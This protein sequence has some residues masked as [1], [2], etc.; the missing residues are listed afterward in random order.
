[1]GVRPRGCGGLYLYTNERPHATDRFEEYDLKT[2]EKIATTSAP[3]TGFQ[4]GCYMGDEFSM[5]AHSAH[6][7]PARHF[8]GIPCDS[9]PAN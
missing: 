3:P 6:V 7:D 2:G 4:F 8:R 1:M 9:S 5:L